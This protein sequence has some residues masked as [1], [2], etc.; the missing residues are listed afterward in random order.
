MNDAIELYTLR[1]QRLESFKSHAWMKRLYKKISK[2]DETFLEETIREHANLDKN[3]FEMMVN[4][5]FLDKPKPKN[6]KYIIELLSNS[7][8]F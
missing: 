7:N 3:A 2:R 6:W 5:L 4:R 1:L 8:T